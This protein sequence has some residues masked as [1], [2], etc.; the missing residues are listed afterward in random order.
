M[1]I[2]LMLIFISTSLF[3]FECQNWMRNREYGFS[4]EDL[5]DKGLIDKSCQWEGKNRGDEADYFFCFNKGYFQGY[6]SNLKD[7]KREPCD[8]KKYLYCF[9]QGLNLGKLYRDKDYN[10]GKPLCFR[11]AFE[12]GMKTYCF[13]RHLGKEDD[14]DRN[15]YSMSFNQGIDYASNNELEV[16]GDVKSPWFQKV[17]QAIGKGNEENLNT[18][19][20]FANKKEVIKDLSKSIIEK[21]DL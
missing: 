3:G 20:Q 11:N 16:C 5:R 6:T 21:S 8:E 19:N 1:R 12:M 18:K 2:I 7:K 10:E 13:T 17:S 4:Y 9:N 15:G 14:K